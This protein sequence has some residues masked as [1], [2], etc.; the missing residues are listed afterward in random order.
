MTE[1]LEALKV[2]VMLLDNC[3]ESWQA[4]NWRQVH[5][6]VSRLRKR[7]YRASVERDLDKVRKLQRLMMRST[8]NKLLAIYQVTQCNKGKH[9]AGVDGKIVV[10][11]AERLAMYELLKTYRPKHVRPVKRV[12]ILKANGKQRPLGIPTI[13]DRCQQSVIKNALEPY[14]EAHFEA[15][16]YGFRPG[17]STHDAISRVYNVVKGNGSRSWILDGDIEGAFDHVE[18]RYVMESIG[19]FPAKG[20]VKSW[21]TSGVMERG[22]HMPTLR[23]T[24][25]G[26]VISPLLLNVALHGLEQELG[27]IYKSEGLLEMNSPYAMVRYADDFVVMAKSKASCQQALERIS[28]ALIKRG[29]RLSE[30]KTQIR[31]VEE[32]IDF[33]GVNIRRWIRKGKKCGKVLLITPSK[34]GQKQFRDE[35]RSVWKQIECKPLA[36]AIPKLN[37]KIGDG[38][39]IIAIMHLSVPLPN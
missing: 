10:S 6:R 14:W 31:H 11:H 35:L 16:S 17:R 20:W 39:I 33:L 8:A 19:N 24:P 2:N 1:K 7:I 28:D 37:E 3:L 21:L 29:L 27:V 34:S 36:Y 38:E 32:G 13:I 22:K 9:T 5:R 12:Y 15:T 23:G 25:Q 18:H 30:E 4:I 26:G